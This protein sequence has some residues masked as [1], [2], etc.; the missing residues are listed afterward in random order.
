MGHHGESDVELENEIESCIEEVKSLSHVK[1]TYLTFTIEIKDDKIYVN[2]TNLIFEGK[3][4]YNHLKNCEEIAIMLVSLGHLIDRKI[5]YYQKSS[6][7]KSVMFNA[8]AA[9]YIELHCDELNKEINELAAK[10]EYKT[11]FRY[12]PGYG[13]FPL[14][15]QRSLLR[16]LNSEK[17][18]VTATEGNMMNPSKSVTAVIGFYRKENEEKI[19]KM[20]DICKIYETCEKRKRGDICGEVK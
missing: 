5:K 1:K 19:S 4:I 18:G 3:D 9:E 13:D 12:S 2:N 10:S 8:V 20:C 6:M 15:I 17:F 14:E 11:N 7:Y 16:V